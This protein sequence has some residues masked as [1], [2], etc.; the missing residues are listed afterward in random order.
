M[1]M[2]IRPAAVVVMHRDRLCELDEMI[3]VASD[4]SWPLFVW[5]ALIGPVQVVVASV[6]TERLAIAS[7]RPQRFEAGVIVAERR[8]RWRRQRVNYAGA[9]LVG[10]AVGVLSA[11]LTS[12]WPDSIYTAWAVMVGLALPL[13][14]Y[15]HVKR[16]LDTQRQRPPD[17][18][19]AD[20]NAS[21]A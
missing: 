16:R 15:P 5:G 6:L 3:G 2:V 17:D 13:A 21:E 11:R 1:R 9:L 20:R 12:P 10:L 8:A 14:A 4:W 18:P 19:V 7:I